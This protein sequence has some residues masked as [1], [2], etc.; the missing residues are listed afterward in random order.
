[1]KKVFIPDTDRRAD[2]YAPWSLLGLGGRI[3]ASEWS[4]DLLGT[5]YYVEEAK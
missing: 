5:T 3:V 4:A 1:M 2:W